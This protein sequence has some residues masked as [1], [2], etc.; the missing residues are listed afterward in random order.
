MLID[1]K[2]EL[3]N[4]AKSIILFSHDL[5]CP[6]FKRTEKGLAT[7]VMTWCSDL[8]GFYVIEALN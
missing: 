1:V 3:E 5:M 8:Q 2:P 6:Q 4:E 7:H